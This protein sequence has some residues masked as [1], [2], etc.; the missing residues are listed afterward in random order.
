[1]D[2]PQEKT[3]TSTKLETTDRRR[4][5]RMQFSATALLTEVGT[6]SRVQVRVA[7]LGKGGCY[8]D[9]LNPFPVGAP[10]TIVIQH[11]NK[12][13]RA[14]GTVSYALPSMGMGLRF[15]EIAP[16]QFAVLQE[17]LG[18]AEPPAEAS[19]APEAPTR[20]MIDAINRDVTVQL[21]VLLVRQSVISKGQAAELL[22]RLGSKTR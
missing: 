17:W 18:A 19:D 4:S 16:D 20:E 14:R 10:V 22:E 9:L 11:A 6:G 1:M 7:D 3:A 12:S 15:T 21:I 5:P 8:V 2:E 13:F